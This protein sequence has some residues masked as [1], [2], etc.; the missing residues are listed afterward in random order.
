MSSNKDRRSQLIAIQ[1]L[2]VSALK[3]ADEIHEEALGAHIEHANACATERL[4]T[5][6]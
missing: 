6:A 4:D 5:L 1:A 2:L 3:I